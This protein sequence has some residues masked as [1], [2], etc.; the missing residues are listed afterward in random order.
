MEK[1]NKRLQQKT[2]T[3]E[4]I[5]NC[6]LKLFEQRGFTQV[7]TQDIAELAGVSHGS[8]FVHF[9]TRDDLI[10][11]AIDRFAGAAC[12]ETRLCLKQ[13]TELTAVLKA[14]VKAIQKYEALYAHLV[15]ESHLL[16][17]KSRATV[18]ELNAVISNQLTR[19]LNDKVPDLR[20]RKVKPHFVFNLWIGL[21]NHYLVNRDLFAPNDSVMERHGNELV[22]QFSQLF[23]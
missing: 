7:K 16:P 19:A 1:T 11:E 10:V 2:E 3:R 9:P 20:A 5:L 18:V 4:R 15:A 12:E 14:H 6:A 13:T 8:I 23:P 21:I 22:K 17:P